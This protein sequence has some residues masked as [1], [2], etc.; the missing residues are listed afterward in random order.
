MVLLRKT[1]PNIYSHLKLYKQ[2][3]KISDIYSTL[4]T[5]LSPLPQVVSQGLVSDSILFSIFFNDLLF[6]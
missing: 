2:N 4:E 5:L 6:F 3:V 1:I